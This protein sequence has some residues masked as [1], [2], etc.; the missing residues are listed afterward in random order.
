MRD[1]E[2]LL[3]VAT[4][5]A[6]MLSGLAG[7]VGNDIATAVG[8][9]R[10]PRHLPRARW[11]VAVAVA[12]AFAAADEAVYTSPKWAAAAEAARAGAA[13]EHTAKDREPDGELPPAAKGE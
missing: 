11:W 1:A 5:V 13:Q 8:G 10:S 7:W 4:G 9:G 6:G 12:V 3:A 2:S